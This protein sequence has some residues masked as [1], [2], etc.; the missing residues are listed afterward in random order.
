MSMMITYITK[1][2]LKASHHRGIGVPGLGKILLAA[3][4]FLMA[5]T[6]AAQQADAVLPDAV[7]LDIVELDRIIALVNDDVIMQSELDVR[8]GKV[9]SDLEEKNIPAPPVHVLARQVAE[10]LILQRLQIQE[11]ERSGIR[12]D[13]QTL[14]RTVQKIAESNGLSLDQFR[15][16]LERDGFSFSQFREDV[17]SEV[18]I[19]RIRSKKIKSR[20]TVSDQEIDYL[21][22]NM[23]KRGGTTD[24]YQLAHILISIPEGSVAEEIEKR[25]NKMEE[26]INELKL[27]AD[28]RRLAAAYSDAQ[29]AMEGG[30]LGWR[31][32]SELPSAFEEVVPGMS[33]GDISNVIRAPSGFHLVKLIDTR[34]EDQIMVTQTRVRHI[35]IRPSQIISEGEARSRIGQLRNRIL[36]GEDFFQ[37]AR[38]NSDDSTSAVDGGDLGWVMPETLEPEFEDVMQ[39][40]AVGEVSEP[41]N[42]PFGW[43]ILRVDD[44]RQHDGTLEYRRNKARETISKRKIE[45]ELELWLHRLR[46][47]AYVELK[48]DEPEGL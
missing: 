36:A 2:T 8:I 39:A 14:N 34:G 15:R 47:E 26:I 40:V 17:R 23:A 4:L 35:L 33:K 6:A 32:H 44:R 38:A 27:G 10:R 9:R 28:F 18:M 5:A 20:I 7:P 41:F 3:Y 46:D 12:I 48:L 31:R 43:H 24:S 42:T 25:R 1:A 30:D 37:L 13:D 22:E 19:G 29:T 21:L 16:L 45:E 11:A